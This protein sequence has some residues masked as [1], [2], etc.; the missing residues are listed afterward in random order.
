MSLLRAQH[1]KYP[2]YVQASQYMKHISNLH[3]MREGRGA[4]VTVETKQA[5]L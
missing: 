5:T 3:A 4:D 1:Q 2:P